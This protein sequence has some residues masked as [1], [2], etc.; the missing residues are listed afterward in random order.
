VE[1][2]ESL[3]SRGFGLEFIKNHS[4]VAKSI[5]PNTKEEVEEPLE[6]RGARCCGC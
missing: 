1:K 5:G 2:A 3:S 6:Q 4:T